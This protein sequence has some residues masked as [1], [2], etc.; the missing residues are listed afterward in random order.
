VE[1]GV[2]LELAVVVGEVGLEGL[3]GLFEFWLGGLFL[4]LLGLV[5][6]AVLYAGLWLAWLLGQEW[7]FYLLFVLIF[8][9]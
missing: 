7:V 2:F 9:F 8:I 5:R 4:A 6:V 3:E 1:D